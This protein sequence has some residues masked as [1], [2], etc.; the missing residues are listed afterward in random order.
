MANR[1][2]NRLIFGILFLCVIG[3]I[4]FVFRYYIQQPSIELDQRDYI[5]T[6]NSLVTLS[7]ITN[8][9][10]TLHIN[11]VSVF[12]DEDGRFSQ[13]RSVTDG[14][15]N[16]T[17]TATDRFERSIQKNISIEKKETFT[18]PPPPVEEEIEIIEEELEK[19]TD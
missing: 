16:V 9:V 2:I 3:Y 18:P 19:L 14:I 15:T 10:H 12:V 6:N 1:S 13:K 17:I 11:D 5:V 4:V 7:G 8:N